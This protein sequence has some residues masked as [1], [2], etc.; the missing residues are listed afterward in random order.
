MKF[1]SRLFARL[2]II[3]MGHDNVVGIVTC[4]GLGR[5]GNEFRWEHD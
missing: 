5:L 2:L 3:V 1:D 4:C